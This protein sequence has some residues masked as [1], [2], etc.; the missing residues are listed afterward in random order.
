MEVIVDEIL[1]LSSVQMYDAYQHAPF[2]I[3][4]DVLLYILNYRKDV[5]HFW[6]WSL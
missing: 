3:K 2:Q 5:Q 6:I 1:Q 4:V